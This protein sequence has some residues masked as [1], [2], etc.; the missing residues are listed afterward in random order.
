MSNIIKIEIKDASKFYKN[1]V[2]LDAVNF[3]IK[4][5]EIIGLVGPN[6]SG[7]TT[8]FN[9]LAGTLKLDSG[10]FL[11]H[12]NSTISCCISKQGFFSEVSVKNNLM[13]YAVSLDISESKVNKLLKAFSVDFEN[14][15]YKNLSAGMKQKVSLLLAFMPEPDVLI[16]DEPT[17]NLDMESAKQLYSKLKDHANADK[18][19]IVSSHDIKAIGDHCDKF[20][21][22]KD[23][24]FIREITKTTLF[25]EF[26]SLENAYHEII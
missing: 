20:I 7:K 15:K 18:S 12:H 11:N 8:L 25:S 3:T 16:L 13:T 10:E 22:I 1:K 21:F 24:R 23:G 19:S 26:G 5:G 14:E 9:I 17:S 6:G 4:T 2:I